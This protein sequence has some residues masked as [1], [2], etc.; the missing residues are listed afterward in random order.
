MFHAK[1]QVFGS[2]K[3]YFKG[4]YHI[5]RGSHVGHLTSNNTLA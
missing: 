3:E 4:S 2:E 5:W 1:F